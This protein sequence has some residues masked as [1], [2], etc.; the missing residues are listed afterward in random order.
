MSIIVIA[1]SVEGKMPLVVSPFRNAAWRKVCWTASQKRLVWGAVRA[2]PCQPWTRPVR[3]GR[4]S[5]GSPACLER[6]DRPANSR[7][8][9]DEID[10]RICANQYWCGRRKAA[11]LLH[12][13]ATNP[14]STS[15]QLHNR[16]CLGS[17]RAGTG[18]GDESTRA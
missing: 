1:I 2:R 5:L 10:T 13:G 4:Q 8:R 12:A 7:D 18:F 14:G 15:G 16:Q 17:A 9:R 3:P 6:A 11:E